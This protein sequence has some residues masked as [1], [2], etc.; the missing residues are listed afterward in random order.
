[1]DTQK[2]PIERACDIVGS[3]AELA[4]VLGLSPAQVHQFVKGTRPVPIEYCLAIER[5]TGGLVTRQDLCPDNYLKIWP[6]LAGPWDGTERRVGP[7]D[8]RSKAA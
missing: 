8:R 6:D 3:Q 5:V 1:M 7:P 4:R 2:S